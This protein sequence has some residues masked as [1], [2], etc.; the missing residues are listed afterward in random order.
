MTREKLADKADITSQFLYDIEMGRKGFS[1]D[2]LY[3]IANALSVNSDYILSGPKE[4]LTDKDIDELIR[5]FT[6]AQRV[7]IKQLLETTYKL[8]ASQK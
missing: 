1:A 3:R 7:L 6:P 4:T 2:T 8:C 5:Y